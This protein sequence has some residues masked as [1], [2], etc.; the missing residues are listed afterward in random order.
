MKSLMA[1]KSHSWPFLKPVSKKEAKDY[2]TIVRKPMALLTMQDKVRAPPPCARMP[3]LGA[4]AD[5]PSAPPSPAGRTWQ[6]T[7]HAYN[8]KQEFVDDLYLII[9]N[10]KLYNGTDISNVYVRCVACAGTKERVQGRAL[11]A[12]QPLTAPTR[13]HVRACVLRRP[14][15]TPRR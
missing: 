6:L 3:A 1:F 14:P 2:E 5:A 4:W 10:C 13:V 15:A 9:S 8:S 12:T 11:R 7:A